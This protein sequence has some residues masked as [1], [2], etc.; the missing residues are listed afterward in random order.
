MIRRVIFSPVLVIYKYH[1]NVKISHRTV[2]PPTEH[3]NF[4][5][6]QFSHGENYLT[7]RKI[8]ANSSTELWMTRRTLYFLNF[9]IVNKKF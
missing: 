4:I 1:R 7:V 3:N 5:I 9:K 8:G 6:R 2:N